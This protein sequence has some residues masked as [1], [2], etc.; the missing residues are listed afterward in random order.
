MGLDITERGR[1]ETDRG[2]YIQTSR[3]RERERGKGDREN[4][5]RE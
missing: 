5:Q 3:E 1:W 2:R 4:R